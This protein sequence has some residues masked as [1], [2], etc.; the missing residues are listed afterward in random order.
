M[1]GGE[2]TIFMVLWAVMMAIFSVLMIAMLG[3][4]FMMFF[5]FLGKLYR[6][7]RKI[8][9]GEHVKLINAI[10]ENGVLLSGKTVIE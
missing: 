3:V 2:G 1:I 8:L 9:A 5:I 4:S 10:N 6:G 7:F